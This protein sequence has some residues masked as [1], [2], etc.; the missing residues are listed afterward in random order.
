MQCVNGILLSQKEDGNNVIC[1]NMEGL[2]GH[3]AKVR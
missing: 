3:Y 2:G 1:S